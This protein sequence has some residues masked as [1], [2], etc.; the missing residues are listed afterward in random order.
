MT[1]QPERET[2]EPFSD[3]DGHL[4]I[5]AARESIVTFLESRKISTPRTLRDDPRFDQKL[6]C[7]VTLKNNDETGSLRGCIGFAEPVYKLKQALPSA[8]VYAATEDPRFPPVVLVE[9]KSLLVEVSILTKPVEIKF[10]DPKELPEKIQVGV[11]G[12]I[13]KWSFGSGLLLP[14]VAPE[15]HWNSI[16]FLRNLSLKAGAPSNQWLLPGTVIYKFG[17][18]VFQESSPL[19]QVVL[20]SN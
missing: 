12:L 17:A 9:L 16:E 11:D 2:F 13:M 5:G 10:E 15:Y 19:G 4:L 3:S 20:A 7:F 6:G 18:L 8:A 14:Q 1:T